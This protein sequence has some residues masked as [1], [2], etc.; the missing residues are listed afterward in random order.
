MIGKAIASLLTSYAP[1]TGL[2]SAADIY[3]YVI[4]EN[5]DLP[6]IIYT[7]DSVVPEYDKDGW[8]GD[9]VTFSVTTF[10]DD[11]A[12]LQSIVS[13]VRNAL[14]WKRGVTEGITLGLIRQAGF[15]EGY[16][17]N[18]NVYVNR[19]TFNVYVTGY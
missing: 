10:D 12:V 3:P 4:N 11:Y 8:V 15:L 2:V 19:L 16:N 13:Q 9:D 17:I 5:T 6:A 7:I 18:E 1:L 14:E